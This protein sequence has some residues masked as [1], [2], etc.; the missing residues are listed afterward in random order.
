MSESYRPKVVLITGASGFIG[1]RLRDTLLD[2]GHDVVALTRAGSPEPRR[3]RAVPVDYADPES[4]ERVL[5]QERPEFVFHVAG[6]TKG[7]TYQQYQRGNVMPTQ[8]LFAAVRKVHPGLRRFVHVSSLAAYGPSA[9]D[10]PMREHHERKPVEFYGKSKLEAEL[11]LEGSGEDV[12]WTI[13][14]P[15]TVYGPGDVDNL[16]LFK[17][18]VQGVN[19]FFGNRDRHMSAVYVDDLIRGIREAAV[20]DGTRGKGYF[21]CDGAPCTWG[22]YQRQIVSA[23]GKRAF[24][25]NVPELFLDVAATFGEL[26]SRIDNKPRLLNRQK[27]TLGKQLAWTCAHDSARADFGYKPSVDVKEGMQR[28]FEWYREKRWL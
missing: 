22:D 13:I 16:Q 12:A 21:L 6:A 2:D 28:T 10:N 8:N 14:R 1:S 3:G 25:V 9:P 27:A 24:D 5:S 18:A 7:V 11:A 26:V 20:H 4:L 19:L 23:T 15:P 17:L